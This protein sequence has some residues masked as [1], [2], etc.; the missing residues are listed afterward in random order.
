LQ[1][2]PITIEAGV[3]PTSR[4]SV[5]PGGSTRPGYASGVGVGGA[6]GVSSSYGGNG[7]IVL[8][9]SDEGFVTE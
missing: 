4:A 9:F 6:S 3:T 2:D 1:S 8:T 5:L 7:A